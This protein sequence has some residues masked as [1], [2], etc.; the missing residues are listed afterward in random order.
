MF[1]DEE[2]KQFAENNKNARVYKNGLRYTSKN[3]GDFIIIGSRYREEKNTILVQFVDTGNIV[4]TNSGSIKS[5]YIKD[6]LRPSVY[7]VGY[8][9]I[10]S[11]KAE[12]NKELY[13][14][15]NSMLSRCYNKE[16]QK[17]NPTYIGCSVDESW[18]NFQNYAKDIK[19]LMKEK[20]IESLEG[21]SIDKDIKIPN[22]KVYSKDTVSIVTSR[23]NNIEEIERKFTTGLTYVATRIADSYEEEFTNQSSFAR[24]YDLDYRNI[25]SCILGKRHTHKGWTFK[26]KNN[27][28]YP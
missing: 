17:K 12:E 6:K 24:K 13:C 16:T 20:G 15:W 26:V 10:G 22:N 1:T 27:D 14:R 3:Y 19:E 18:H 4:E 28:A 5:G 7:N 8:V 25:S 9:G 21:Y 23:E 11:Y 2:L